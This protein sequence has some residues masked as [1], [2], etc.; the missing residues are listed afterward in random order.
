MAKCG[1]H[2]SIFECCKVSLGKSLFL[3]NWRPKFSSISTKLAGLMQIGVTHSLMMTTIS[4]C[5]LWLIHRTRIWILVHSPKNWPKIEVFLLCLNGILAHHWQHDINRTSYGWAISGC[6]FET[7]SH[8][9]HLITA[10][11]H[12][13]WWE[14]VLEAG[15]SIH[16]SC[17]DTKMVF[18]NGIS[19][20]RTS[21]SRA[22]VWYVICLI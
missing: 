4:K 14:F 11:F 21:S 2:F 8:E 19:V 20:K 1:W 15:E 12:A 3:K 6:H 10:M 13:F 9:I 7:T 17:L 22:F 18:A 5:A 16:H